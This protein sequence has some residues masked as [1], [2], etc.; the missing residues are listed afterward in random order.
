MLRVLKAG[1]DA[2]FTFDDASLTGGNAR[3]IVVHF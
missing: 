3:I 2:L 1:S